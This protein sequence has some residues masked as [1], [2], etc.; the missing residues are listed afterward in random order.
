MLLNINKLDQERATQAIANL[1][2]TI[3]ERENGDTPDDALRK[4]LNAARTE[5]LHYLDAH[6][7]YFD[8]L[9]KK[10]QV[11]RDSAWQVT[12]VKEMHGLL[13][14]ARE[15]VAGQQQKISA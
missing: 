2:K 14:E 15:I 12:T 9:P 5:L 3:D 6:D 1:R 4:E 8:A 10:Q 11:L 7:Q 13:T